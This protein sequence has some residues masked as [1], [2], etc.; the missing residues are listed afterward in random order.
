MG[1]LVLVALAAA[2]ADGGV[3]RP[4]AAD[5]GVAD[6]PKPTRTSSEVEALKKR[7]IE[8]EA[9]TAELE[10]KARQADELSK[11]LDQTADDLAALRREVDEREEAKRQAEQQAVEH[12]QRLEAIARGLSVADQQLSMGNTNIEAALRAAE[13]TYTGAALEHLRSVRTALR[14]GDVAAARRFLALA[15]SEAQQPVR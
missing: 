11:K 10:R 8:L 5:A 12:K 2:P 7:I 3:A 13:A 15:V 4:S 9:R 6:A 14:N 1:L